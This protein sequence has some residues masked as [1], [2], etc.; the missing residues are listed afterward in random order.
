M[1][2]GVKSLTHQHSAPKGLSQSGSLVVNPRLQQGGNRKLDWIDDGAGN[3]DGLEMGQPYHSVGLRVLQDWWRLN[4]R[5]LAET[6]AAVTKKALGESDL[7]RIGEGGPVKGAM[8]VEQRLLKKKDGQID[9]LTREAQNLAGQLDEASRERSMQRTE[10]SRLRA[11]LTNAL[12]SQSSAQAPGS[13]SPPRQN[14]L[15]GR[16]LLSV[17]MDNAVR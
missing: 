16:L 13:A 10:L 3:S 4:P 8:S 6:I 7:D 14:K 5:S 17:G 11:M 2:N 1:T 15:K 12:A 9:R